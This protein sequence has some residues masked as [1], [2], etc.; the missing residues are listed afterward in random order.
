[1]AGRPGLY[2]E[3]LK[4]ALLPYAWRL[5]RQKLTDEERAEILEVTLIEAGSDFAVTQRAVY[6]L[7]HRLASEPEPPPPRKRRKPNRG[8][9]KPGNPGGPGAPTGNDNAT[10]TGAQRNPVIHEPEDIE[11]YVESFRPDLN[12]PEAQRWIIEMYDNRISRHTKMMG[13]VKYRLRPLRAQVRQLES[14]LG[15]LEEAIQI[16]QHRRERAQRKLEALGEDEGDPE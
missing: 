2:D 4:Y 13:Q 16:S 15:H 14:T 9:F 3:L 5:M 7:R 6:L 10:V 1:M 8:S 12:T 11:W